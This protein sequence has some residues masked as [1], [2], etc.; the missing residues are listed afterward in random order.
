M[1]EE[2]I[3]GRTQVYELGFHIVPTV[4]ENDLPSEVSALKTLIENNK[5]IVISEEF[6]KI[7]NL[8]YSI[9]K[10]VGG[11]K[12]K[13]DTAYFGW[14]KFE[15]DSSL[16][17]TVEEGAKTNPHVLRYLLVK[18]VKEST[19]YGLK[20]AQSAKM[21]GGLERGLESRKPKSEVAADKPK[22]SPEEMD[23]TIDELIKE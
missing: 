8:S 22:M 15:G 5:G 23:K 13:C 12:Q 19:L 4:P 20:M 9:F 7:Q 18:T 11:V 16:V 3:E 17:K 1:Q 2:K 14:I 6:P 21:Q 10:V